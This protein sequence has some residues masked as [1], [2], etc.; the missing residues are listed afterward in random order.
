MEKA[1]VKVEELASN[2]KEYI[3]ARVDEVKFETAE[4][5]SHIIS[6]LIAGLVVAFV[7]VFFMLFG[8]IALANFINSQLGNSWSGFLIVAFLYMCIGFAV[9]SARIKWIKLPIMNSI[10]RQLFKSY[11]EDK[12]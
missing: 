8:S 6:N 4:K 2:F 3:N 9:W 12:K 11:E 1:F 7:F 5:T 10:T